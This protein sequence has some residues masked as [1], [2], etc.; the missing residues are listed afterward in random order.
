MVLMFILVSVMM[1]FENLIIIQV[2]LIPLYNKLEFIIV[3][4]RPFG[5]AFDGFE[6]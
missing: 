6:P 3:S 2:N 5:I 1:I 4:G